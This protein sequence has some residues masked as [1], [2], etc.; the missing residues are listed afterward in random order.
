M[1]SVLWVSVVLALLA[2][3]VTRLSRG[4]LD[5]AYSLH[6]RTRAELAA[7]GALWTA[8]Y[9]I[10]NEG[11]QA[12]RIDG[13]VYA[14]HLGGAE[15]RV[16]V[17]DELSRIDLNAAHP[18]LLASLFR[19]AGVE[20]EKATALSEAAAPLEEQTEVAPTGHGRVIRGRSMSGEPFAATEQ[21]YRLPEM[22]PELFERVAPALTVYTGKPWPKG[23]ALSPLVLAATEGDVLE[24]DLAEA[25]NDRLPPRADDM[26]SLEESPTILRAPATRHDPVSWDLLRIEA[27]AVTPDGFHF[28]REAVIEFGTRNRAPWE[29]HHWRRGKR[30]LF[31]APP[32]PR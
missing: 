8:V 27:E 9:V 18:L 21:L 20:P 4:D 29:F 13:T 25:L 16:R 15:V 19:A 30:V 3:Q 2:V 28:S 23:E 32:E 24:G 31:P 7:D 26:Q 14:W 10:L 11:P 12:W 22:S 6:Q 5:L 17:T 1:I